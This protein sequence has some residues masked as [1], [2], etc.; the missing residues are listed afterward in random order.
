MRRVP[1]MLSI[2][3]ALSVAQAAAAG[4]VQ[5]TRAWIRVL[6][7]DLPAAGYATLENPGD[8]PVA[9]LDAHSAAYRDIMLHRSVTAG[10]VSRMMMVR[11]LTVPA[12]GRARLAPGGYH[13]MLMHATRIVTPGEKVSIT[14]RFD[15]G[16]TETVVFVAMPANATGAP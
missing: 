14:L 16:N 7:G 5:V 1:A 12:H 11:R 3:V 10:G 9:L 8:K 6:P 15:D 2:A 4:T 13:L